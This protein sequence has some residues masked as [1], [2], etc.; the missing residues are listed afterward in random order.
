MH[1]NPWGGFCEGNLPHI[2][3]KVRESPTMLASFAK[4][5]ADRLTGVSERPARCRRRALSARRGTNNFMAYWMSYYTL[6]SH[7]TSSKGARR[8]MNSLLHSKGSTVWHH[9][10]GKRHATRYHSRFQGIEPGGREFR[11][12]GRGQGNRE[13]SHSSELR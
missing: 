1:S 12:A 8:T 10:H 11:M 13:S 9:R 5:F 7:R 2:L 3:H 4:L 6:V